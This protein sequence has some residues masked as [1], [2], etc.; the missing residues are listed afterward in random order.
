MDISSYGSHSD[1]MYEWLS[2]WRYS[3]NLLFC[4]TIWKWE[5]LIYCIEVKKSKNCFACV[6][7]KHKEYCIL[8]KQYT[9]EEYNKL[10]PK[11]IEH[12]VSTWEWWEFFPA[13]ISPFWYNETIAQ[14]HFPLSKE[15]AIKKWFNWSN[16]EQPFPKVDKIIE[17]NQL[18]DN[19]TDIP[20][21][22]LN[23]AIKCEITWKPFKLIKEELTFYRKHKLS[24]PRRHPDQRHLDRMKLRND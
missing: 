17:A 12:M 20:D 9:K 4:N 23:R 19:I 1:H 5:D 13:S 7:L 8:N 14:E 11:I 18:P 24:I 3:R 6:N 22:I 16:Y 21:D 10:V 15:E 2:V